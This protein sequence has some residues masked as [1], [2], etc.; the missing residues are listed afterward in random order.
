MGRKR[1]RHQ[2]R[3]YDNSHRDDFSRELIPSS[4]T[5]YTH[6]QHYTDFLR[7]YNEQL[8]EN[9]RLF[10]SAESKVSSLL[11]GR[12]IVKRFNEIKLEITH[13]IPLFPQLAPELI[14]IDTLEENSIL[15]GR[16]DRYYEYCGK[17][18][19]RVRYDK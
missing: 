17:A 15:L 3:S 18:Y 11:P 2:K 8:I 5:Q 10:P 16:I 7:T 13:L 19:I 12:P 6:R 4:R 9:K 14:V 1:K